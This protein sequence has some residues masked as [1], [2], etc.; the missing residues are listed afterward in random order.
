MW[1][2]RFFKNRSGA[3]IVS[4]SEVFGV[5]QR[6]KRDARGRSS[7][8]LWNVWAMPKTF[9]FVTT[10]ARERLRQ[11]VKW[12]CIFRQNTVFIAIL[13]PNGFRRGICSKRIFKGLLTMHVFKK[14]YTIAFENI[15]GQK[16][17]WKE[18]P[19]Y[20]CLRIHL[21][22]LLETHMFRKT[23]GIAFENVYIPKDVVHVF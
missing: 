5:A 18:F 12:T 19:K 20:I 11:D 2:S 15:Y 3:Y 17:L 4:I 13:A 1:K 16:D 6:V 9:N 7:G 10:Q 22:R 14:T 21:E 8:A 23:L